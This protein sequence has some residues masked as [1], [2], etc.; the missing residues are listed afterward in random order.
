M[1]GSD[2][3]YLMSSLPY[4]AF[5]NTK[6]A[7]EQIL[8]LLHRYEGSDQKSS[9]PIDILDNEAG[10]FLSPKSFEDF[11]KI[12]LNSIHHTFFHNH[13]SQVVSDFSKS[14]LQHRKALSEWR[15]PDVEKK[16]NHA[17]LVSLLKDLNPLEREEYLLGHQ[18]KILD[19]LASG[20][21]ADLDALIIYKLKL[22]ILMRWWSFDAQKGYDK[23]IQITAKN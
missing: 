1:I 17:D 13:T 7:K 19:D 21:F 11:Q 8:N 6:E 16:S 9:S 15:N 23:F 3:E 12:D 10:K 4:L 5:E 20:H 14:M 22:S 2:L 18:W